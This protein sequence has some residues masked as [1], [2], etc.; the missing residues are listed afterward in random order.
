MC[1]VTD[2]NYKE[3]VLLSD[4]GVSFNRS[5]SDFVSGFTD[6]DPLDDDEFY[7]LGLEH[8]LALNRAGS[9]FL[10]FTISY[11]SSGGSAFMAYEDFQLCDADTG[12]A[13]QKTEATGPGNYGG[14]TETIEDCFSPLI[15]I[16]FTTFDK[17]GPGAENCA[18]AAGAGWWWFPNCSLTCNP[19]GVRNTVLAPPYKLPHVL[20]G[21]L[22]LINSSYADA[23]TI[24]AS[25][26]HM[27][28]EM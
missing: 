19:L 3:Y 2:N 1:V 12:Y 10:R 20:V 15:G 25:F 21:G 26:I 11:G 4:G 17:T 6:N 24:K 16:P 5:W 27:F 18:S 7:W 13:I 9:I 23:F 8:M 28:S 14:G 22:D